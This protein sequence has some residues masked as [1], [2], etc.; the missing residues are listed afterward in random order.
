MIRIVSTPFLNLRSVYTTSRTRPSAERASLFQR[1]S[2]SAMFKV[3]PV[4]AVRIGKDS[5]RFFKRD[6]MLLTILRG[7]LGIPREHITVYTLIAR[8]VSTS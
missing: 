8:V 5:R 2:V 3:L 1:G 4:Q 6:A 7:F